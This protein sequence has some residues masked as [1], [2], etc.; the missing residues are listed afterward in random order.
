MPHNLVRGQ[1]VATELKTPTIQ[2]EEETESS[3]PVRIPK[4]RYRIKNTYSTDQSIKDVKKRLDFNE[5]SIKWHRNK[6]K[7]AI[8]LYTD[9]SNF[10]TSQSQALKE[11]LTTF[12]TLV[13]KD[14]LDIRQTIMFVIALFISFAVVMRGKDYVLEKLFPP[15]D[16]PAN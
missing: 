16:D 7:H 11:E 6:N 12:K 2:E 8:Q 10:Q 1:R 13:A 3:A 9:R 15:S 5:T 14:R 4:V